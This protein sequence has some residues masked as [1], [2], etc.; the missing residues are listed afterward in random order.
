MS[1]EKDF[2]DEIFDPLPP[3]AEGTLG[4]IALLVILASC[5]YIM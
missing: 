3:W 4:L 5:L 2:D 1:R